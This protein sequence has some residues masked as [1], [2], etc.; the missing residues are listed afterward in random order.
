LSINSEIKQI[1][2]RDSFH[3]AI[4]NLY[5]TSNWLRD[6]EAPI[7]KKYNLQRQHFNVLRIVKG[8]HPDPVSPG[9][10]IA[11][12]LDKK[13]DLTRLVDKMVKME[14]LSRDICATNRRKVDISITQ[15]GIDLLEEMS[16]ELFC[17]MNDWRKIDDAEAEELSRI[18]DKIR[19]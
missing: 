19:S 8:K 16:K 15:K 7:Y 4:V 9:D 17:V 6:N 11:V 5:F 12:M 14:L 3:K 1:K 13:R 18:L 2:F 10:I